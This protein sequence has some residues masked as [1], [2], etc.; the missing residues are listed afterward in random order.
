[1]MYDLT[2]L[3]AKRM[4]EAPHPE[5]PQEPEPILAPTPTPRLRAPLPEE[6]FRLAGQPLLTSIFNEQ[7]VSV[8]RDPESFARFGIH[9]PSN[10]LLHGRPGCG[11]T[12]A[13]DRLATYLGLPRFDLSSAL[14]G[15]PYIHE[16]ARKI[17]ELFQ[18]AQRQAPSVVIIDEME[19]FLSK[20]SQ[21]AMPVEGH[22]LEETAEFLRILGDTARMRVLVIGIT[23]LLGVVDPAVK[24]AGRFDTVVEV[25]MPD[26]A[27]VMEV[28]EEELGPYS[29][30]DLTPTAARL[31]GHPFAE[32][33]LLVRRA[34]WHAALAKK[35]RIDA[36]DLGAALRQVEERRQAAG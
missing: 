3:Q 25:G 22:H 16:S 19:A 29:D 18:R 28:L 34:K 15:S 31:A 4:R 10:I 8:F 7:V 12:V 26:E 13:A 17:G 30:E 21:G 6:P 24:R 1:S 23:N 9:F 5:P 14:V 36:E 11:K 32:V 35:L 33:D 27:A 2:A 20:R